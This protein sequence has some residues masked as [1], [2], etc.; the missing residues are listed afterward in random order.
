MDS[1]ITG[2]NLIDMVSDFILQINFKKLPHVIFQYGFK[3]KYTELSSFSHYITFETRFLFIYFNQNSLLT[4][5]DKNL[6]IF[7]ERHLQK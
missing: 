7:N 3:E 1:N 6:S 4:E 2:E 5:T